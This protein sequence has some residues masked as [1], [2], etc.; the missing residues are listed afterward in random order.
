MKIDPKREITNEEF[1]NLRVSNDFE[2]FPIGSLVMVRHD[3]VK[4]DYP[5]LEMRHTFHRIDDGQWNKQ[6][7]RWNPDPRVE[8]LVVLTAK[9]DI[10]ERIDSLDFIH[11]KGVAAV[12]Y[13]NTGAFVCDIT[14][15]ELDRLYWATEETL[16]E[17]KEFALQYKKW[18][19]V[20]FL[21]QKWAGITVDLPEIIGK[22][23]TYDP[24]LREHLYQDGHIVV[25]ITEKGP[26]HGNLQGLETFGA[27]PG[28]L[29]SQFPEIN[30]QRAARLEFTQ[31]QP[32]A[33][34]VIAERQ[35]YLTCQGP[36]DEVGSRT[37]GEQ[38]STEWPAWYV[39]VD[40]KYGY[41]DKH[42]TMYQFFP[43]EKHT[44]SAN[45]TA[46]SNPGTGGY[47]SMLVVRS[48]L[49]DDS[50]SSLDSLLNF[51]RGS[52]TL[53]STDME[54]VEVA[55]GS[56]EAYRNQWLSSLDGYYALS[57]GFDF[58]IDDDKKVTSNPDLSTFG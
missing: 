18:V 6:A 7:N 55:D 40:D 34:G 14:P 35:P 45:K 4:L 25:Q 52:E 23:Q 15:K 38:Q 19:P 47:T 32:Q 12:A 9:T 42:L 43:L 33:L 44:R 37:N 54:F 26:K 22:S 16:A 41:D 53:L 39:N 50:N 28:F 2:D 20:T 11:E 46:R 13:S 10:D 51:Y 3:E 31:D 49:K 56:W 57:N 21:N 8:P 36:P 30:I 1:M 27:L 24:N 48:V 29:S 58:I 5:N 17:L